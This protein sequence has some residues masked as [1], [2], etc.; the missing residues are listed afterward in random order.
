M[1]NFC[2]GISI[3]RSTICL[4]FGRHQPPALILAK[5]AAK[6]SK[7]LGGCR[8]RRA[9]ASSRV[10]HDRRVTGPI[11]AIGQIVAVDINR[12][13]ANGA[14]AAIA[15]HGGKQGLGLGAGVGG[16]VAADIV[17]QPREVEGEGEGLVRPWRASAPARRTSTTPGPISSSGRP[18]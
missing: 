5:P 13:E 17:G 4:Y 12:G 16:P 2:T 8:C 1:L 11:R 3:S 10:C 14:A 18:R 15:T 9:C 7:S 6:Q